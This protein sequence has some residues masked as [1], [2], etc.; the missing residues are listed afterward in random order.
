MTERQRVYA[1]IQREGLD[2]VPWQFDLT[3]SV[4]E[5]LARYYGIDDAVSDDITERLGDHIVFCGEGKLPA[6]EL[7]GVDGV[8]RS[9]PGANRSR[10]HQAGLMRDELGAVWRKSPRDYRIGD[11]GELVRCPLDGPVL[12]GYRFPESADPR[13]WKEVPKIRERHP[14]RFL[15]AGGIGL[16]ENGWSLCGFENYLSY[17][18]GEPGFIEALNDGLSNFS[19]AVTRQLRGKGVDGIRYGDDWGFQDRLMIQP[20]AW[21]KLYKKYYRKIYGAARESGLVVMIHSCGNI[22]DL[23]SDLIEIGVQV[24]HP[25]QPEAMDVAYCRREYGRDLCFWGGL[26]SQST[27]P[28][29]TAED[30]RREV[31]QRLSLFGEGGYIL[32]PAG[33]APAETP[34]EN[35]LA[36]AEEAASQLQWG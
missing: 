27:L 5:K 16:F 14:R 24:V 20:D 15:V 30:V 1:A 34:V 3:R 25:L 33:A 8:P 17:V 36:V 32:A 7:P 28:L 4:R 6:A 21:R 22:T 29:G 19:A 12:T 35:I 23:L 31:R 26:G 10:P 11:W 18:A 9:A 2:A 13:R